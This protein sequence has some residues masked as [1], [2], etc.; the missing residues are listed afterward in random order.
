[1]SF[2]CLVDQHDRLLAS[3]FGSNYQKV[4][5][6]LVEY[7]KKTIGESLERSDHWLSH[8]M[9]R[10]FEGTKNPRS[11]K[12]NRDFVS[13]H[14]DRVCKVLEKIPTG[15]VTTYGLISKHI[16]SGPRAV[17]G[18]V[19]SNP[20]SIF[21]PCHRVVPSSLTIGNYSLCGALGEKGTVTKHD[22]LLREAVPINEDR[23]DLVAVW[24]PSEGV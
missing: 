16:G 21:V 2:G 18:A 1:M 6:H 12:L 9:T 17:G 14:Q 23:I 13:T 8:E 7:S 19:A 3:S 11:V 24:D 5:R 4:E 15:R 22:L 20:W 10:R